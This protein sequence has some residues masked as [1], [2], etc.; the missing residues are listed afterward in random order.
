MIEMKLFHYSTKNILNQILT[1]QRLMVTIAKFD[2]PEG[3]MGNMSVYFTDLPPE[4]N[5][6]KLLLDLYETTPESD[7]GKKCK[8][9]LDS[10]MILRIEEEDLIRSVPNRP[11]WQLKAYDKEYGKFRTSSSHY[12]TVDGFGKRVE[13]IEKKRKIQYY[14][15]ADFKGYVEQLQRNKNLFKELAT[16]I[17][18]IGLFYEFEE[19]EDFDPDNPDIVDMD[20]I[21]VDYFINLMYNYGSHGYKDPLLLEDLL[22]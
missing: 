14:Q 16:L 8:S 12:I 15:Y 3:A 18:D 6:E 20:M 2:D 13:T 17:R 5:D 10:F 4:T 9:K 7:K 21:D 1:V 22:P 19:E 11:V